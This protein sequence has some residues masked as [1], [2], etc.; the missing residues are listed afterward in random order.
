MKQLSLWVFLALLVNGTH[1]YAQDAA[2]EAARKHFNRGLGQAERGDFARALQEFEAAY[3]LKPH[4][5]A[6][7]NIGQ[8]HAA[9]A[10]PVE[11]IR[12]FERYLDEAGNR[13]SYVRRQQVRELVVRNRAKLGE[14]RLLGVTETTRVWLDG[15]EI[16]RS[17]LSEPLLLLPGRHTVLSSQAGE[18]KASQTVLVS[19]AASVQ[20]ELPARPATPTEQALPPARASLRVFC[21]VP[22]VTVEI[23][24]TKRG[25]TPAPEL[26]AVDA[27]PRTVR[28]FRP[29]YQPVSVKLVA[30]SESP[31]V[32][33]CD[34]V[35]KPELA[36]SEKSALVVQTVPVDADVFVDGERFLGAALPYGPHQLRVER[37]GFVPQ[38]R[39]ISLRARETTS[40]QITLAPT[41]A[42]KAE[43]ARRKSR[44]KVLGYATGSSGLALALA[45]VGLFAWN[46]TRYSDWRRAGGTAGAGSQ[47]QSVAS[48][49]RMDDIAVGCAV[50]GTGL[51]G[52]GLWLLLTDPAEPQ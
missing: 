21:D 47:I 43:E 23:D 25:A 12:A 19:A 13:V 20:L 27:G 42:R 35:R 24:A 16:D 9:L 10:Q 6:L 52:A 33:L 39:S 1:A 29:G 11:A 14:V 34:Q 48:M 3:A 38:V 22:G 50:L 41:P 26:W 28:F 5:S 36:A 2:N 4:Y 32:V 37:S 49:Q 18:A 46:G 51:V 45:G 17:A 8:A 15:T 30:T 7:Y 40:Y 31:A 44:R